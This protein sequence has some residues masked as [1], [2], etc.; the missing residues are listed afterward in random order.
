[1]TY[2]NKK[3]SSSNAIE[4]VCIW[5]YSYIDQ[6]VMQHQLLIRINYELWL[7]IIP[8]KRK[9]EEKQ[10]Q[11]EINNSMNQINKK[12]ILAAIWKTNNFMTSVFSHFVCVTR[13]ISFNSQLNFISAK[14]ETRIH[15][16][17]LIAII[18][19][20]WLARLCNREIGMCMLLG[21]EMLNTRHYHQ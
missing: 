9:R 10:S 18:S 8:I 7:K 2:E 3:K 6:S 1:M 15:G 19:R 17:L 12:K 16:D 5:Y 21:C 13:K 11:T 14:N 20:Y 4:I